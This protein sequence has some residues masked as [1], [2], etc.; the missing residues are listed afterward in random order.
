MTLQQIIL[1]LGG[2]TV[3]LGALFAFLGRVWLLRI[4]EKE[5]FGLQ[6]QLDETNRKLQAELDR[7]LHV[8]KIQFDAEFANYKSI[9]ACLVD[10]RA[11]TLQIRPMLDFVDPKESREDRLKHRLSAFGG[12]FNS[13]R[14]QV[15]K[16]KPF[17]AQAVYDKLASV[18]Q[19]CHSEAIDAEYH[20][21]PSGEYWKEA[22]KNR[23]VILA[24]IDETCDSIRSRV[25]S[26]RVG[27]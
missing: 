2:Y 21:R 19:L 15:E 10:L 12:K 5:K 17:Y 16:N 3:I 27:G 26:V 1:A 23:K 11:S 14:E 24:A 25:S 6:R 9:W 13:L 4:V 20:E 18:V 7:D 8:S 22:E